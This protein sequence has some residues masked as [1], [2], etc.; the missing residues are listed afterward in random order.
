LGFQA[1]AALA[2]SPL[3]AAE[4]EQVMFE[5]FG[6]L[7]EPQFLLLEAWQESGFDP[8]G[9][10]LAGARPASDSLGAPPGAILD[11]NRRAWA[12]ELVAIESGTVLKLG[13]WSRRRLMSRSWTEL[14]AKR[15]FLEPTEFKR[16]AT[17]FFVDRYPDL[18]E[19][20]QMYLPNCA[21]CHGRE[22]AGDG[23]MSR[24]LFPKP[25][26]Y[27]Y[28]LFKFAAVEG[29][30]KP[31]RSDLVR[32]LVH[33]LPGSAMPSF[34]GTSLAELSAL[35]DYVRY[36]S[37]RGEVEALLLDEWQSYDL[38][39]REAALELYSMIWERWLA[40]SERAY[41]V[42][43]PPREESPEHLALG[44]AV[45]HEE[46]RGNCMSCHGDEGR[47]DGP[48]A[49]MQGEDGF[50]YALLRDE[51]GEFILPRDLTSGIFRGGRRPEDL[52]LRIHCGIPGTP[53]SAL[54][55]SFDGAGQALLS[56]EE[57]WALVAYVL[58]LSGF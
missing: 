42:Q 5:Y 26:N 49:L 12:R 18:S 14:A 39:P 13:P 54:G 22:G 8:N 20:A 46:A 21:R 33:G 40:A 41:L 36:L 48:K 29:G 15:E 43:A 2:D 35:V 24:R 57:K 47:G 38:L 50:S 31:R 34:R 25:R 51:W 23:P 17:N 7:A 1:R 3:V 56:E 32:T 16:R 58:S 53:M 4:F 10:P 11:D 27:Q 44:A 6:T 28:G 19:A 55:A 45:F 52:Y 37:I 30:S 9:S